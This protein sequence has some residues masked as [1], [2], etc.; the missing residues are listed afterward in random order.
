MHASKELTFFVNKETGLILWRNE[1]EKD[2]M[3]HSSSTRE[4][5]GLDLFPSCSK[6]LLEI[7]D[8]PIDDG[9]SIWIGFDD[10]DWYW[11]PDDMCPYELYIAFET[12]LSDLFGDRAAC[13]CIGPFQVYVKA[14]PRK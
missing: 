2:F 10:G 14:I 6:I 12:W 3:C 1:D 5:L 4:I 8:E 7:S 13:G 9:A 11:G